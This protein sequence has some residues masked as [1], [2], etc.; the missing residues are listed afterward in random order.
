MNKL[1]QI[2]FRKHLAYK[3]CFLDERGDLTPAAKVV[4]A[5]LAKFAAVAESITVVSPVSRQTD[6]PA[7]FQREGRREVFTRVWRMLRLPINQLFE[8]EELRDE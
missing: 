7:S 4:L 6:V 2:I 1:R 3:Q 5:D 8:N